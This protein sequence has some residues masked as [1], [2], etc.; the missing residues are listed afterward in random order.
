MHGGTRSSSG[1]GRIVLAGKSVVVD[2][3]QALAGEVP[4]DGLSAHLGRAC[5]GCGV[6]AMRLEQGTDV[7]LLEA[8]H[9]S[10]P[11]FLVGEVSPCVGWD[12]GPA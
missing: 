5:G 12:A 11:C 9:P 1:G 10:A 7:I 8:V 3:Q 6:V 2:E 4:L